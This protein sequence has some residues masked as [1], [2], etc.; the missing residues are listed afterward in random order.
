MQ[1][2]E[3]QEMIKNKKTFHVTDDKDSGTKRV[4]VRPTMALEALKSKLSPNDVEQG[5]KIMQKHVLLSVLKHNLYFQ[6]T[7]VNCKHKTISIFRSIPNGAA[8]ANIM[9]V[10][11]IP[12]EYEVHAGLSFSGTAGAFLSIILEKAG[13]S[14]DE[15]YFTDVI[16]CSV[17]SLDE[18]SCYE[19]IRN[20]FLKEIDIVSPKIIVCNGL[21]LLKACSTM[22]IFN[23][24]PDEL[25]YG[26]IYNIS[27]ETN[28]SI[29]II[30]IYDLITVLKK[31]ENDYIRCKTELWNQI[32]SIKENV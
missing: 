13:I 2:E 27:T 30:A 19:C 32:L 9:F 6:C 1:E 7:D 26:T 17:H 29:K 15:V 31:K 3:M 22:K 28:P 12:T 21:N 8:S 24:L 4:I 25:K 14:R 5:I 20:Y 18:K 11:K 16:K 10:N 23:G